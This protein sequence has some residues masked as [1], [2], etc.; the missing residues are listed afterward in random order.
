ML[1]DIT[2]CRDVIQCVEIGFFCCQC[3]VCKFCFVNNGEFRIEQD[4]L[5][6]VEGIDL[7]LCVITGCAGFPFE[8]FREPQFIN[9]SKK[10]CI[11]GKTMMVIAFNPVIVDIIRGETSPKEGHFF[12][13]INLISF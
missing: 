2:L 7:F 13:N 8:F 12:K 10:V 11:C 3:E 9:E 1:N 5:G 4:L 6:C